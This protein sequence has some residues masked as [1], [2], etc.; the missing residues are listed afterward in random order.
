MGWPNSFDE[1]P[2]GIGHQQIFGVPCD[3]LVCPVPRSATDCVHDTVLAKQP[4]QTMLTEKAR[5]TGK[6]YD[7]VC[8]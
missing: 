3:T 2:S 7:R 5:R 1:L 8:I 6:Q 4:V